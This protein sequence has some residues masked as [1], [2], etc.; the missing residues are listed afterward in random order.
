MEGGTGRVAKRIRETD[1]NE[2]A[3]GK[4]GKAELYKT[5]P[6]SSL[7]IYNATT[8]VHFLLGGMGIIVGYD[9]TV[10]AWMLGIAYMAV[11]FLQMYV[12][13]PLM[14]CPNCVYYRLEDGRCVSG[15]NRLSR[16]IAKEGDPKRFPERAG[17][18]LSHNKFYM[19]SL[20]F[21]IVAMV[22][23]LVLNFSVLLLVLFLAVLGLMLFR[24]FV[25][26]QKV[27]C[28]HCMAKHRCPNAIAMGLA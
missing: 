14:V 2:G 28:V 19:G 3:M 20:I 13:M 10:Y 11:A 23:A 26:F 4:A 22:P 21:P 8:D 6:T 5:Y 24:V 15:L 25:V 18:P 1:R 16:R 17:G 12:M 27:A 7:L 9:G